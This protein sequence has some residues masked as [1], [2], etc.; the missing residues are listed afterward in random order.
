MRD[1]DIQLINFKSLE[2]MVCSLQFTSTNHVILPF[3]T[4]LQKFYI[5]AL[6]CLQ[7]N[8]H[9]TIEQKEW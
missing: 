6:L 5:Y 7:I 4:D 3:F 8:I 1:C 2:F 9:K